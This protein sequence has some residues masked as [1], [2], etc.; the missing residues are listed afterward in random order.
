MAESGE[1]SVDDSLTEPL[2]DLAEALEQRTGLAVDVEHVVAAVVLANRAG[3]VGSD[4]RL[5]AGDDLLLM[6][7]EPHVR[8][9]FD[10]YGGRVTDEEEEEDAAKDSAP[11][12][13]PPG[14]PAA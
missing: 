14:P 9:V 5:R 4:K 1:V 7:L 8:A 12:G 6:A 10:R 2:L 13:E 11:P 3:A